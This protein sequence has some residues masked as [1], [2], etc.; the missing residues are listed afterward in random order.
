MKLF[1][2]GLIILISITPSISLVGA[3]ENTPPWFFQ[4]A[5]L[6]YTNVIIHN[7]SQQKIVNVTYK[8]ISINGINFTYQVKPGGLSNTNFTVNA[9]LHNVNGFPALNYTDLQLLNKGNAS[10]INIIHIP[11]T[12]T[13]I[14]VK[15]GIMSYTGEGIVSSDMVVV[16]ISSTII[17]N[18]TE[19][20]YMNYST[21]SGVLLNMKIKYGNETKYVSNLVSTNVPLGILT[22]PQVIAEATAFII[23]VILIVYFIRRYRKTYH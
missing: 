21:Y 18:I 5:Y 19:T 23:I 1:V 3:Q 16:K 15:P 14:T 13:N 4:N 7:S 17:K 12:F 22:W 11:W 10:F 8:I 9:D 20:T 2:L 6:N